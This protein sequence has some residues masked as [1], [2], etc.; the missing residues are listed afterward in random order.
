MPRKNIL[1]TRQI[2]D[3]GLKLLRRRYNVDIYQKNKTI[4]RKDLIKKLKSKKYDALLSILTDKIDGIILDAAGPQLIVVA[5]YAVGY[6]NIDLDAAKER[7]VMITNTP[8]KEIAQTVAEHVIAQIF[9]LSHRIVETDDFARTGKYKA[10]GPEAFLGTDVYGKTLGI[11]GLGRIGEQ[12]AHRMHDGFDLKILY[13]GPTRNKA[14]ENKYK[15]KHVSLT[16]L[17]KKSDFVTLHVPLLDSTYHLIGKAQLKKMKKSAFLINTSRG[18]VIDEKAL[19]NALKTGQIKG[20]ALDVFENGARIPA[21][22]RKQEN[23]ILTPHTASATIET[24][25]AMSKKAAENIIA[26]LSNKKPKNKIV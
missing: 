26:A 4:P 16:E 24:R 3:S 23:T 14:A 11:I 25:Q 18:P 7:N 21:S 1:V 2:P 9:S 10:W 12:L 5:N 13:T 8:G 20:A 6:D 19:I 17:L 15:A 22:L